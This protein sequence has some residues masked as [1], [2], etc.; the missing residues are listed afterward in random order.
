MQLLT[1]KEFCLRLKKVHGNNINIIGTYKG[2]HTKRNFKNTKGD[3]WLARPVDILEGGTGPIRKFTHE[4]YIQR[5]KDKGLYDKVWPLEDYRGNTEKILHSN[6]WGDE[7]QTEPRAI[8]KGK[9]KTRE[10]YFK[11]KRWTQEEY[12]AKV[13]ELYGTKV[14]VLGAYLGN[15]VSISHSN[16]HGDIW[17]TTPSRI[18]DGAIK[19]KGSKAD[20]KR[21][22]HEEYVQKLKNA[23]SN[24]KV[25][26]T[27]NGIYTPIK[28]IAKDGKKY[29][30]PPHW[31]LKNQLK[32]LKDSRAFT[33]EQYCAK[34]KKLYGDDV[35]PIEKYIN[36]K[37]RIL[38]HNKWNEEWKVTPHQILNGSIKTNKVAQLHTIEM[39]LKQ[40]EIFHG[41]DVIWP[42][43]NIYKGML[44]P[45]LHRNKFGEE[46]KVAPTRVLR[47]YIRDTS[48]FKKT[49]KLTHSEYLAKLKEKYGAKVIWPLENYIDS[50]TPILHENKW[51]D[52]WEISPG[53]V[54]Y[55]NIKTIKTAAKHSRLTNRA[56]KA[57]LER[58]YG[59]ELVLLEPYVKANIKCWHQ[60]KPTGYKWHVTPQNVVSYQGTPWIVTNGYSKMAVQWLEYM[61]RKLRINIQHAENGG[62]H[63][64]NID[65][66][67]YKI[68]GIHLRKKLIFEFYG[69]AYHGNPI[70]YDRNAKPHPFNDT[71]ARDLYKTTIRREREL[72]RLGYIVVSVWENDFVENIL[73]GL[74]K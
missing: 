66:K 24:L 34:L 74:R 47:G 2:M 15:G 39:Y 57:R 32:S 72:R 63:K 42:V 60:H 68:D 41:K 64:I 18:L 9:I 37:T 25:I 55:G 50:K 21:W 69:D 3:T 29:N 5:L 52:V 40:I 23:N 33:H 51:G 49:N 46:W 70:V 54:L 13:K 59:G 8:L 6:I 38:H 30:I 22:T 61:S 4:E 43:D 35:W 11:Q 28:H 58:I 16:S 65:G 12:E 62:E 48:V 7:W 1:H 44:V 26:G 67:L 73:P 45:V 56:Y 71:R 14:K 36:N 20:T 27:Y 31:A 53:R 10:T 17:D 19:P